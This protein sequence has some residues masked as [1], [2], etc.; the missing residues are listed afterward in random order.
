[1]ITNTTNGLGSTAVL[2]AACP[3][4]LNGSSAKAV[5]FTCNAAVGNAITIPNPITI[6]LNSINN[7]ITSQNAANAVTFSGLLT[8]NDGAALTLTN[9][10]NLLS[11][12]YFT[13]GAS[14][15]N[16]TLTVNE[17]T[18]IAGTTTNFTGTALTL[19]GSR[20][21]RL[22]STST[23]ATNPMTLTANGSLA[24]IYNNPTP[25]ANISFAMGSATTL[26][27]TG[28]IS[29][30]VSSIGG[31]APGDFNQGAALSS[32]SPLGYTNATPINF[33]SSTP[34]SFQLG[35]SGSPGTSDALALGST[36]V[37]TFG[38][39][40]N[41]ALSIGPGFTFSNTGTYN[42]VTTA[43]G[44]G[45]CQ[46]TGGAIP[47]PTVTI[48]GYTA[49]V[50][51]VG[52][53]VQ[54]TLTGINQLTWNGSVSTDMANANNWT[55]NISPAAA[56]GPYELIFAGAAQG[57]VTNT[58]PTGTL[59]HA[60]T[61]TSGN[62]SLT[63]NALNIQSGALGGNGISSSAGTVAV[64]NNLVF[65]NNNP[66]ITVSAGTLNFS[67]TQT[68]TNLAL[69]YSTSTSIVVPGVITLVLVP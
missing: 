5:N 42:I 39:G 10:V 59:I 18:S 45:I 43:G 1:M 28:A 33:T 63:G 13:A 3:V 55:P 29:G 12:L 50:G 27:G 65:V 2:A 23:T 20:T 49:S 15:G 61:F 34:V 41:F 16:S 31:F 4:I 56:T 9:N 47:N 30:A 58:L 60:L 54:V 62:Y 68:A 66:T 57:N 26:G 48:S 14:I 19:N 22:A 35:A 40:T 21:L 38:A 17:F 51:V 44:A 53:N 36:G 11:N 52:T 7:T 32:V 24:L 25:T 8:V 46:F 64:A 6:P 67:R 37:A 69:T